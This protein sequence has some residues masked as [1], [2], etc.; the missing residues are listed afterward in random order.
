MARLTRTG[1]S[2]PSFVQQIADR[3][4]L[5]A[6]RRTTD[7][8]DAWLKTTLERSLGVA[9]IQ[10]DEDGDIPIPYGSAVL[11]LRHEDPESPFLQIYAP[12]LADFTIS[13]DVYEAV[14]AINLQVPM[15]KAVVE[16]DSK[17]IILNSDVLIA[18]TLSPDDLM[19]AIELIADAADHFD[20][21]L[22]KR[23]GG[24]TMLDDDDDSIDV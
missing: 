5:G 4:G 23:F 20:T 19:F 21:L 18:G 8:F 22:Q 14:N 9:N 1:F 2:A 7:D 6:E 12:L 13:S 10:R 15:A 16:T 17:Q 3:L 24:T 11:F